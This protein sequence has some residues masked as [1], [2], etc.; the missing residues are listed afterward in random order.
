MAHNL[1]DL[2]ACPDLDF[3][4]AL[5]AAGVR[6][7]AGIDEAG[8]GPLAGPVAAAAVILPADP[9]VAERLEGVRD[10]KQMSPVPG[11]LPARISWRMQWPGGWALPPFGRSTGWASFQLP[12]WL[13]GAPWRH[14]Q[15]S[16][17]ICCWTACS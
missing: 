2:P 7:V 1:A 11:R 15:S 4:Q 10:S 13:P 16:L 17:S 3:E 8:R 12:A 14:C 9:Q 5:W 6:L